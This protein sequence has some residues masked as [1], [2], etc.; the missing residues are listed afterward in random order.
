MFEKVKKF[1]DMGLYSKEQVKMFVVKGKL[2]A[3]EYEQITGEAY[4]AGTNG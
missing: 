2:T 4:T 1:Y 3:E